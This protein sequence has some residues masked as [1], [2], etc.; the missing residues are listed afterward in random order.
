MKRRFLPGF[1]EN[2]KP[3]R[4]WRMDQAIAGVGGLCSTTDDL[5][6]YVEAEIGLRATPL[7]GAMRAQLSVLRKKPVQTDDR[8]PR[9]AGIG[10]QV[11][12]RPG[13]DVVWHD[14]GTSGYR[15]FA[16]W[17]PTLKTGIVVLSNSD[18]TN[19][20]DLAFWALGASDPPAN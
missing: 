15:T 11:D 4:L 7:A 16:G 14:G 12:H 9:E 10:W 5:L 19:P 20:K 3:A 17:N 18:A 6:T 1:D 8:G 13:A 2:L